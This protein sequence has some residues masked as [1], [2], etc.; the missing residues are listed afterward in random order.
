MHMKSTYKL[1][2]KLLLLSAFSFLMVQCNENGQK[3]ATGGD[4][5]ITDSL[6]TGTFDTEAKNLAV[7]P[8]LRSLNVKWDAPEDETIFYYLVEWKGTTEDNTLYSKGVNGATSIVLSGLYNT[9]YQVTVKAV[10]DQYLKSNG[11]STTATPTEDHEGPG[12]VSDLNISAVAKAVALEW[13]NPDDGDFD[14]ISIKIQKTGVDT[15]L[16]DLTLLNI[17]DSYSFGNLEESTEY[18]Y[19]ITTYDYIGNASEVVKDKFKTLKEVAYDKKDSEDNLIWE[20]VDFSSQENDSKADFAIDGKDDTFWHSKWTG[21]GSSVPHWIIID[22]KNVVKPSVVEIFKRN[23][24]AAAQK[25]VKIEGC[26]EEPGKDTE[27]IDFGTHTIPDPASASGQK[28]YITTVA[29]A[30]YLKISILT[31]GNGHAMIRNINMN[32]LTLE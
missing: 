19:E 8:G 28:C 31:S 17:Y 26:L 12:T 6:P 14:H 11:I 21:G 25:T 20:V 18:N 24:G 29:D 27:W 23:P 13:T 30:R 9:A 2:T 1:F 16:Y 10:S 5:A 32:I 22:L 3:N 15:V 4:I 7:T